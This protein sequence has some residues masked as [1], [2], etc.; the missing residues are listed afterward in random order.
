MAGPLLSGDKQTSQR[1]WVTVGGLFTLIVLLFM[2]T[3]HYRPRPPHDFSP[4]ANP[5]KTISG[6]QFKKPKDIPI[7][8]MIFFGRKSRVEIL[9]CYIEVG[10]SQAH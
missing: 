7:V 6:P 1:R 3:S 10:L 5:A 9:R 4:S 8:G 2:A